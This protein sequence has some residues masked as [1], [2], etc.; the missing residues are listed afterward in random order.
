[1][2]INTNP[3]WP[4]NPSNILGAILSSCLSL[5]SRHASGNILFFSFW[6]TIYIWGDW[7]GG[8]WS[9]RWGHL[10][11][12]PTQPWSTEHWDECF[13]TKEHYQDYK[14]PRSEPLAGCCLWI[15]VSLL[16]T[17]VSVLPV[18]FSL[19]L[20][21]DKVEFTIIVGYNVNTMIPL[22][23]VQ[24]STLWLRIISCG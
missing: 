3:K 4:C 12:T 24:S 1:M 11:R 16:V 19:W 15:W 23:W 13:A 18:M 5:T 10:L 7:G 22:P 6:D 8:L 2:M 14:V 21:L 17:T 9:R 20:L